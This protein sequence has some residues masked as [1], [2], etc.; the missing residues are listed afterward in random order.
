MK[1]TIEQLRSDP[2]ATGF[3]D[4]FRH[5]LERTGRR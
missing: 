4:M 2:S 3:V 1:F 5:W